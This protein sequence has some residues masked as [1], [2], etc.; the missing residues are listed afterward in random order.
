MSQA[1]KH[2]EGGPAD[3]PPAGPGGP[4][5]PGH[6][7]SPAR[8]GG[9][10]AFGGPSGRWDGGRTPLPGLWNLPRRGRAPRERP[11]DLSGA[12]FPQGDWGDPAARLAELYRWAEQDA[13]RTAEWYLAG[14][15]R[16][17]RWAR[18][19]RAAAMTGVAA[20]V[21]LPLL[22]LVRGGGG[23]QAAAW[24]YLGLLAAALGA[25]ADRWF[26]LTSGWMRDVA[27]AQAVRRRLETLRFD[28]ASENVREVLGPTDGTAGEAAERCLAVLRRFCE[29]VSELVREETTDWMLEFRAVP[30]PLRTQL[31]PQRPTRDP[32]GPLPRHSFPPYAPGRPS[33]PRQRPPEGG[34]TGRT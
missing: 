29:D 17:R 18:A 21:T 19:A 23:P 16:K 27:T 7:W 12:P 30:G 1:D 4:F 20:A 34:P 2:P 8:S 33:M 32:A 28:W 14:R 26:G 31:Q 3:G 5:G 11:A 25:G 15:S 6:L 13:L 22:A 24:G 10:V 9:P